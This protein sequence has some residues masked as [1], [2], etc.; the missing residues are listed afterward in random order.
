MSGPNSA[1]TTRRT[2]RR[3]SRPSAGN[4]TF[5]VRWGRVGLSPRPLRSSRR[6]RAPS[7]DQDRA[8]STQNRVGPWW[9]ILPVL[10]NM[11]VGPDR[12]ELSSGSLS[13]P[14]RRAGPMASGRSSTAGLPSSRCLTSAERFGVLTDD[15]RPTG[16]LSHWTIVSRVGSGTMA[17][18]SNRS[19]C[20]LI[21]ENSTCGSVCRSARVRSSFRPSRVSTNSRV[22]SP[23][24]LGLIARVCISET[25][26]AENMA[27]GASN[28]PSSFASPDP[29]DS[30]SLRCPHS[31]ACSRR[32]AHNARC[33]RRNAFPVAHGSHNTMSSTSDPASSAAAR[34]A[35]IRSPTAA[36]R[37]AS[38][39]RAY[40]MASR[41][42]W[43]HLAT[44]PESV[45]V[46][47]ESPVPA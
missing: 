2:S 29:H 31:T 30:P 17:S 27:P 8:R 13:I 12:P 22:A 28:D 36:R 44:R 39:E 5:S 21:S 32:N 11:T 46:P 9:P 15:V 24:V 41:T 38:R 25:V 6:H 45:Q 18:A 34:V 3:S 7:D 35:P 14:K 26:C 23:E 40:S 42:L 33:S 16:P 43:R 1:A 4:S 20:P 37:G 19:S 10:R 47:E